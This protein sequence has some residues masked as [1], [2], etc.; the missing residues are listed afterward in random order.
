MKLRTGFVSNSS[1][2][3]F[4]IMGI[5]TSYNDLRF[6]FLKATG[7]EDIQE[8]EPGCQCDIDRDRMKEQGFE[9][10]PKCKADLFIEKGDYEDPDVMC[11]KLGLDY[12]SAEYGMYVGCSC[13]CADSVDDLIERLREKEKILKEVF[14]KDVKI[15]IHSGSS[16]T[17]W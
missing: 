1:T 13:A 16:S 5:K 15:S 12:H 8:V 9:F 17:L 3:S 14:G 11:K 10:C 7:K 4:C 2:T 6:A